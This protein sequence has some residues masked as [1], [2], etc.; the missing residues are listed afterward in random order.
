V[1]IART[2]ATNQIVPSGLSSLRPGNYVVESENHRRERL[3]AIL[4]LVVVPN[5][6]VLSRQDLYPVRHMPIP[7][8]PNHTRPH[9]AGVDLPARVL[10]YES[11]I[12]HD[13]NKSAT[14]RSNR[15][16]LEAGI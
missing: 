2:A 6:D 4:A 10:L 1:T 15:N 7:L 16:R 13:E 11:R 8:Q 5:E 3:S 12:L 9:D 14:K